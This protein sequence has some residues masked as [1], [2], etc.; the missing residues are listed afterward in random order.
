MEGGGYGG[1]VYQG[2]MDLSLAW[3]SWKRERKS[4]ELVEESW[5]EEVSDAFLRSAM[6]ASPKPT[7]GF[8]RTDF[9]RWKM[10]FLAHSLSTQGI[11]EI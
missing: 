6:R 9:R 7:I 2:G 11:C 8:M 4:R 1:R 3:A 5:S 10:G